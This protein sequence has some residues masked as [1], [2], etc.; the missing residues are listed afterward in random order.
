MDA[1]PGVSGLKNSIRR[2]L[3]FIRL[4][5]YLNFGTEFMKKHII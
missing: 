2:K 1:K 3:T 5:W 4:G